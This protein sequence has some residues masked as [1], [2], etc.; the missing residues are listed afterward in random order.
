MYQL[1]YL[2]ITYLLIGAG[3]LLVDEYGGRFILLIRL[4][5]TVHFNFTVQLFLVILGLVLAPLKFLFPIPPGPLLFGDFLP[6]V[7][8]V[9][10]VIYHISQLVLGKKHGTFLRS[11]AQRFQPSPFT[12]SA[13]ENEDVL[14]K[15]GSLIE[16]NKRNLGYSILTVAVLHFL[17]PTAVLL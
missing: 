7:M 5:N 8:I 4:R 2:A 1:H 17:F 13:E 10:L 11:E 15:T 12:Q 3:L 16:T 6:F 14:K 9:V